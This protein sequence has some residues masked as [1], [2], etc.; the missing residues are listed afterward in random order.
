MSARALA[1]LRAICLALPE[2]AEQETWTI[3]TWRIRGRIFCMWNPMEGGVAAFW[4]KAPRGVQEMLVEAAPD[5]FFRP[6]YV[7][8]K[9]WIGLRL[10]G[11]VDWEEVEALVR[12][13]WRMTAPK[14]V[15]AALPE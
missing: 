10:T 11:R 4:C 7:G 5:R 12:R 3:P 15:A 13:S 1:R 9:G 2:A 14:R 6:P 8:H